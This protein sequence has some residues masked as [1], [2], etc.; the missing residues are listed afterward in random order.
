MVELATIISNASGSP[1]VP[2]CE[3]VTSVTVPIFPAPPLPTPIIISLLGPRELE[4]VIPRKSTLLT[5]EGTPGTV[6]S[7][8]EKPGPMPAFE[9]VPNV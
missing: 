4:A 5:T 1:T 2:V 8:N 3:V 6:A 9:A 7:T